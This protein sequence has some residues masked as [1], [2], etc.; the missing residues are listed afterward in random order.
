MSLQNRVALAI[1][2]A[3]ALVVAGLAFL[4]LT[5]GGPTQPDRTADAAASDSALVRP[6]SRIIGERGSTDVTFVEFLDFECEACAALYPVVEQLREEYGDRVTFVAR[7][8]PLPGHFNAER[9]ARAVEAAALQGQFEAMY[10]RMYETQSEWGEGSEPLDGLFRDFAEEIG[11]D[12]DRYDADYASQAV[13]DRV[14]RDV[15]DGLS[16]NVS[17]TPTLYVDGQLL[18]PETVGDL[19]DALDTALAGH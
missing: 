2:A 1:G 7:Y 8:Y 3:V 12:M 9:A 13:A 19:T 16:L 17:G 4:V 11:L 5:D 6:D 10:Q 15:E 14:Q 18:Q